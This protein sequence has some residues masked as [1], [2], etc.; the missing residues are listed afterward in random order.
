MNEL[1]LAEGNAH[2]RRT[3][4][5]RLEKH[6]IARLNLVAVD[7]APFVVLLPDFA[8]ERPAVLCEYPLHEPAAI[9]P[10]SRFHAAVQIGDSS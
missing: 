3:A 10:S 9:E 1:T 5:D 4:T 8:R 2:V 6:E 7:R